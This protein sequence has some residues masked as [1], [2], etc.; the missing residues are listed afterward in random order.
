MYSNKKLDDQDRNTRL[1]GT[2]VLK[3][4]DFSFSILLWRL[5]SCLSVQLNFSDESNVHKRRETASERERRG[6]VV[7]LE[8]GD[9]DSPLLAL[10]TLH[11]LLCSWKEASRFFGRS[12]LSKATIPQVSLSLSL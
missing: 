10:A 6:N 4:R 11:N 5:G 2:F 3:E 9:D 7:N 8:R 12:E 1:G